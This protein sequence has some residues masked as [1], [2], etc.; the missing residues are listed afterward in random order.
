MTESPFNERLRTAMNEKGV[1]IMAFSRMLNPEFDGYSR[2]VST[3][4]RTLH[5]HLNGESIPTRQLRRRYERL[6]DL[7]AGSLAVEK[8]FITVKG[9]RRE[10]EAVFPD[11][12]Y[13]I[14][15]VSGGPIK[16]G[17][18]KQPEMRLSSMQSASPIRLRIL[19][20]FEGGY[21]RET[22]LHHRFS[23]WRLNGEWFDENCPELA[24][25]TAAL[26]PFTQTNGSAA[27]PSERAAEPSTQEVLTHGN[28]SD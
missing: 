27:Q 8:D 9:E 5:R 26:A 6:L 17:V 22:Q 13:L 2:Q 10:V 19:C 14:Q 15:G 16:I 25:L 11:Y 23:E 21:G 28:R 1:G 18:A 7:P 24:A 20:L 12:V 3:S 4:K